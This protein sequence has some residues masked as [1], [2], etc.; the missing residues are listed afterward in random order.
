MTQNNSIDNN[1]GET[2]HYYNTEFDEFGCPVGGIKL[3]DRGG[4][5]LQA[6]R[7]LDIVPFTDS[8]F[9]API[10]NS[11]EETEEK[12]LFDIG[13]PLVIH[14]IDSGLYFK[15]EQFTSEY[16]GGNITIPTCADTEFLG[17]PIMTKLMNQPRQLVSAQVRGW[18][19]ESPRYMF[20]HHEGVKEYLKAKVIKESQTDSS[21]ADYL[22]ALGNDVS[23]TRASESELKDLPKCINVMAA[24]F[25]TAEI[26]TVHRGKLKENVKLLMQKPKG[27]PRIF[28]NMG[29]LDCESPVN[30]CYKFDFVE[31]GYI[32][33]INGVDFNY[34]LR[35]I[36]T[37]KIHGV[38]SYKQ[39]AEAVGH[40]LK[41]KDNLSKKEL[42]N[43]VKTAI[44]KPRKFLE[45]SMG[46]LDIPEMMNKYSEEWLKVY[47][48]L[49]LQDWYEQP[50]LTIGGSVKRLFEAMIAKEHGINPDPTKLD[51][52]TG[53]PTEK[54]TKDWRDKL[55][56][57]VDVYLKPNSSNDYAQH[58]HETM[59][60]LAKV[61]GGRCRNNRPVDITFKRQLK[62]SIDQFLIDDIDMAGCYAEAQR[63]QLLAFGYPR[64]AS[65]SATKN[66]EYNS[67]RNWLKHEY[68]VKIEKLISAVR[69]RDRSVWECEE[70]WGELVPGLWQCRVN[71]IEK[72][73]YG[74]DIVTSWFV[75]GNDR[76]ELLAKT[77][78]EMMP[79][80]DLELADFV[81]FDVEC[82]E[83]KL[84]TREII[85]GVV[86]HDILQ[87]ILILPPRERDDLLDKTVVL[88]SQVYLRSQ[89]IDTGSLESNYQK[90]IEVE[91]NW[92]GKNTT[93]LNRKSKY[94]SV[95]RADNSCCAWYAVNIGDLF[96]NKMVFQRKKAQKVHGKKS[97]LDTLFKLVI[98]TNYGDLVSRF[99][100]TSNPVVGNNI[101]ARAR[102]MARCMEKGLNTIQSITDGGAFLLN[103]VIYGRESAKSI[104]NIMG[105]SQFYRHD[106]RKLADSFDVV[107]K[108]LGGVQSIKGQWTKVENKWQ[109]Q[110]ILDDVPYD[111]NAME[112]IDKQAINH[113]QNQI[114]MLDILHK[115]S[116]V[117]K[118]VKDG[119][120]WIEEI[121]PQK[122]IFGFESKDI[123]HSGAFHGA[124]NYILKNPNDTVMKMRSY[125]LK[126]PHYTCEFEGG[127][128]VTKLLGSDASK[129]ERWEYILEHGLAPKT[130]LEPTRYHRKNNPAVDFLSQLLENPESISRQDLALTVGILKVGDYAE[131]PAKYDAL[132]IEP[133]DNK[134][135][136]VLLKE[137]TL[138]QFTFQTMEQYLNWATQCDNL[139]KKYRQSIESFFINED[140]TLNMIEMIEWVDNAIQNGVDKPFDELS[141]SD[142]HRHKRRSEARFKAQMIEAGK[143]KQK[144]KTGYYQ[145]PALDIY[146]SA[147]FYLNNGF[148]KPVD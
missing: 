60:L 21:F 132:G 9:L 38:A 63:Q 16:Y 52:E 142:P 17:K 64:I 97:A 58:S 93:R 45:Y 133:G 57:L 101:T 109:F 6:T 29:R 126:Q 44:E 98:N 8:N 95:V 111:G 137:F 13:A 136:L 108:P 100:V 96:I 141:K 62:D 5:Y 129:D 78:R 14:G 94:K 72:L 49:D 53:L 74:Q 27:Q 18:H 30:N 54:S 65:Y 118:V 110:L 20:L 106:K 127:E 43:I 122:G 112:W 33:T 120:D 2:Y 31:L 75:H 134:D 12:A 102:M 143:T 139:V 119:D 90:L 1:N 76:A 28:N 86:T 104:V 121:T 35:I 107:I 34:C 15:N 124:S 114:P 40:A 99:F 22:I 46:D 23:L 105:F 123:F 113:L 140:G 117:I 19:S 73:T 144:A 82:G 128:I 147:S 7:E 116:T 36:D 138:S 41:Y 37:A 39:F 92:E 25:A 47:Q 88:A 85:N 125:R 87:Q 70:N 50:R 24:H 69:K 66:N 89:R 4:K 103:A 61:E 146:E 79:D 135:K 3:A 67:L 130:K 71:T 26:C 11:N 131:N 84:F 145:H 115:E 81:P 32:I 148:Y 42:E 77:Q 10:T 83:N 59:A 80:D 55:T 56:Q 91:K 68:G 48:L 51:K